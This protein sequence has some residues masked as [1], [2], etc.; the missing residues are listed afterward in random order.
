MAKGM[1]LNVAAT[2]NMKS[3]MSGAKWARRCFG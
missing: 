1:F 2:T 3:G